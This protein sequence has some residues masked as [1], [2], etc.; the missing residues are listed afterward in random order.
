MHAEHGLELVE[1][2][3]AGVE[4]FGV[5][6]HGADDVHFVARGHPVAEAD[7]AGFAGRGLETRASWTGEW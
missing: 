6:E 3:A 5:V 1:G 7:H 2:F 4:G